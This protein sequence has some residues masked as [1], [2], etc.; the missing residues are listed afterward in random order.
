MHATL[1]VIKKREV[2]SKPHQ[3]HQQSVFTY[4]LVAAGK[5]L[6]QAFRNLRQRKE[7]H[8]LFAQGRRDVT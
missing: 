6:D 1:H 7:M 8:S 3:R 5:Y 4:F 2:E